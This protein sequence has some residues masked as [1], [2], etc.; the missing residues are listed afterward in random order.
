MSFDP[1][2]DVAGEFLFCEH[3]PVYTFGLRED[4][5]TRAAQ[6][7]NLGCDLVKVH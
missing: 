3:D 7:E 2:V 1:Q 5:H 6:L 4:Y